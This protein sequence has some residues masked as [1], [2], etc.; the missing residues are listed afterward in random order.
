MLK[1]RSRLEA[2]GSLVSQEI[3]AGSQIK[4]GAFDGA[5]LCCSFAE[6][7]QRQKK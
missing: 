4:V 7:A 1:C 6:V 2:V 5:W 3:N